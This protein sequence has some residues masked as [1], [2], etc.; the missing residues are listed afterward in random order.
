MIVIINYEMGNIA[1]VQNALNK[2]GKESII[3][4]DYNE[5]NSATHLILPGVGAFGDGMKKLETLGLV[6]ILRTKIMVDKTPLLGI[7]LGMQLLAEKSYEKGEHEGLG[8][9]KGKVMG[10]LGNDERIPHVGWNN[11]KVEKDSILL[12]GIEDLC[13]YFVHSYY[14]ACENNQ[15]IASSCQY[16]RT[17][18]SHI[19]NQNIFATQFHPEKSQA[20]GL[21]LLSNFCQLHKKAIC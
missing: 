5:I 12:K 9:I 17:F 3:S 21:Q 8:I 11:I 2:I 7:C 4:N 15:D 1:S 10:F 14:F 19:E 16:E 6:D 18:T 13:F 20:S